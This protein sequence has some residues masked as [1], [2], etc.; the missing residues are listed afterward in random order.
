MIGN[1]TAQKVGE[2]A[3][4]ELALNI[5]E[6]KVK[7][8]SKKGLRFAVNEPGRKIFEKEVKEIRVKATSKFSDLMELLF[9]Q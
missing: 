5:G 4:M 2:N 8:W 3:I 9:L 1:I 7:D 6:E